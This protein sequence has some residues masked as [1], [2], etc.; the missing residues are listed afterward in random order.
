[1]P[2]VTRILPPDEWKKRQIET[3][4]AVGQRNYEQGI[5]R[6][7]KDPIEAGIAAE[8]KW[9]ARI[10]EAIDEER[11]KKA[12]MATNMQEWFNFAM[13]IGAGRLVEGVVKREVKVDRFVK[14]WQPILL[15]HVAKID[16]LPAVTDAD[17]ETRMLEN[18]RGL[19]AL[20]GAWRGK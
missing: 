4:K 19:K 5:N 20:K 3:L 13:N 15:D 1:M 12:L 2:Q 11:R 6:P 18:L 9:A 7:K 16:S 10:K 17:M 8:E 14:A